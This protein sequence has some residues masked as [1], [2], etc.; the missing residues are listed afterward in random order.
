MPGFRNPCGQP[1][2]AGACARLCQSCGHEG[3]NP[4][5]PGPFPKGPRDVTQS[6]SGPVQP[7][8]GRADPAKSGKTK[9]QAA[10]RFFSH[11]V[12]LADANGAE[13]AR[14]HNA[15]V[16][17]RVPIN[18]ALRNVNLLESGSQE[19]VFEA[20]TCFSPHPRETALPSSARV[21]PPSVE[22]RVSG[23]AQS[24]GPIFQFS[25][26]ARG[27]RISAMTGRGWPGL[28]STCAKIPA[29]CALGR[30]PAGTGGMSVRAL[31][32][33]PHPRNKNY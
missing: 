7:S 4:R 18:G 11:S 3:L 6:P 25:L 27:S 22:I 17:V 16:Q 26:D 12:V 14:Q 1:L 23:P 8:L 13:S 20:T 2:A 10:S 30:H 33:P 9:L 21:F 19:R 32:G 24:V 28:G 31:E 15:P 29:I 5:M